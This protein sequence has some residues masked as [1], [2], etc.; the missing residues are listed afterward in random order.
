MSAVS[1]SPLRGIGQISITAH[2]INRAIGFYRDVLGLNFLFEASGLAFFECGGIRLML[3]VPES[4]EFNHPSSVLYFQV[5]DVKDSHR[6]LSER[7]V[8]F[9]SEPH[10]VA[11]LLDREIWMAFFSD[12]EGNMLALMTEKMQAPQ[13]VSHSTV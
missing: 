1:I 5:D 3:S 7:G 4:S 11:R 9:R 6:T 13:P 2:D 8:S 12:S 10:C